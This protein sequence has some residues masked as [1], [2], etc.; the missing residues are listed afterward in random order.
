MVKKRERESNRETERLTLTRTL[1]LTLTLTLMTAQAF[2]RV[3]DTALR[4]FENRIRQVLMSSGSTTF[5]KI[6]NKWNT[7]LIGLMTYYR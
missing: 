3:D 4:Q 6:A 5:T 1:T 7:A 2:L